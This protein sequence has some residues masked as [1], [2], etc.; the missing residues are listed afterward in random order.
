MPAK[1]IQ[2]EIKRKRIY[3]DIDNENETN[4][5]LRYCRERYDYHMNK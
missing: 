5:Q 2:N 3:Y 4:P 1:K